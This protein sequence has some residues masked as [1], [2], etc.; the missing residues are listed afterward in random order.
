MFLERNEIG[1]QPLNTMTFDEFVGAILSACRAEIG[2][3]RQALAATLEITAREVKEIEAGTIRPPAALLIAMAR[4]FDLS[5][6]KLLF[7]Y[8]D[9]FSGTKNVQAYGNVIFFTRRS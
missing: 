8:T 4:Y 7:E 9:L 2:L 5:P 6:S 3:S 1:R